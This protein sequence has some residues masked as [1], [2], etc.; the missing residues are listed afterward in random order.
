[1]RLK[2]WAEAK[3]QLMLYAV[4]KKEFELC[5]FNLELLM[6]FKKGTDVMAYT[7]EM[8]MG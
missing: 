6:D 1:M 8:G 7:L 4:H 3:S 2:W 5:K